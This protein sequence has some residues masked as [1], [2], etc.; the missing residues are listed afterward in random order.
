M[1]FAKIILKLI[2]R[3][4][5]CGKLY[6][7]E[8]RFA[9][10]QKN[11]MRYLD[12]EIEK[13]ALKINSLNFEEKIV[14][15][16]IAFLATELYDF[17]G[18]TEVIKNIIE[19]FP[20]E[21]ENKLFLIR[22][23]RTFHY[24]PIKIKN[25][26]QFCEIDGINAGYTSDKKNLLKMFNKIIKFAPK[27]IFVF[28]HNNDVFSVALL[29]YLKKWTKIKIFYSDTA[30]HQ[31]CIG[32]SFADLILEGMPS[33]AFVT[34]K[35][36]GFKNTCVSW[37]CHLQK[38]KLPIFTENQI[39]ETKK[40]IG[41][42]NNALCTL[43]GASSYKFFAKN[44]S[45]Y[46]EMI[47]R[48]LE[49]HKNLYHI[50]ITEFSLEQ[51][52]IFNSIFEESEVKNRIKVINFTTDF[53][54]FFKC[55]DVF[56]DSF[57]VSS[58]LAMIDLM[59]LKVPFA[60]K[61]NKDNLVFSFHEYFVPYYPYMFEKIE[62]LEKGVEELLLNAELRKRIAEMNFEHFLSVFEGT[63]YVKRIIDLINCDDLSK[64]YD[65]EANKGQYKDFKS[66]ELLTFPY[67]F[68]R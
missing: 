55:A 7:F 13:Y 61:I 25:I 18:H 40:K 63:K 32:M 36:R 47:K 12:K 20:E 64:V 19:S 31:F 59:S 33:T 34:Q 29:A 44:N 1:N 56:I 45:P 43:S 15:N 37:L 11:D 26:S 30:S 42:P 57:P 48:L 17:G 62:D 10:E 6:Y 49:K 16:R 67:G 23:N 38:E 14:N 60:A 4:L 50:L 58:A 9:K 66:V 35:Y 21:Y 8:R 52:F 68:M 65:K 53:K 5:F 24:A 28:I 46:L 41:L 3:R 51:K 22:K 54:L 2:Y 39:L 27:A